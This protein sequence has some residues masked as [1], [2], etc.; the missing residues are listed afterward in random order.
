MNELITNAAK[1]I[2]SYCRTRTN[3]KEEA[4]DLSQDIFVE[5][6]KTKGNFDSEKAFYGFMWAV[7][8]NVYAAW[9]KKRNKTIN[10]ELDENIPDNSIPLVE[11][12]EKESDLRLLYREL[13]LL[14]EQYRQVVIQYYF[15]ERKVSD[16]SKSMNISE[17]MVKFLLFKTRKKLKEGMNM[18]RTKG[19]LSFNPRRM[20]LGIL[21]KSDY[22][23]WDLRDSLIAQNILLACYNDRCTAEEISIEIGV[24]VPY[25]E[26]ELSKLCEKGLLAQK[27]G[28]YETNIVIFTKEF[29]EEADEKTVQNRNNVA[30]IISK[31]LGEHLGDIKSVGF[32]TG[33][34]GDNMLKWQIATI[35]LMQGYKKYEKSLNIVPP[36]K[37]PGIEGFF[38]G[39]E[40]YD[41]SLYPRGYGGAE[42][43]NENG[44]C[45]N[46]HVFEVSGATDVFYLIENQTRTNIVLDIAKGKTADLSENDMSE[47]AEF[48]KRGFVRKT[49]DELSLKFPVYTS[50]QHK[51]LLSLTDDITT[52]IAEET[53]E[54]IKTATD[55]LI[56]H[57]PVSMKKEAESMAWVNMFDIIIASLK[58]MMDNGT[59]Q[60]IPENIY[61]T[62][63]IWQC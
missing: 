60:Q 55:I 40:C 6:L 19:D 52:A 54:F 21:G 58:I 11:M 49:G 37:Y 30:E 42:K 29:L 34:L 46:Y 43:S 53:R 2:F 16:I 32:H 28:K 51:E 9:Y 8:G 44:D 50:E 4:E 5:L 22:P 41:Q 7:A 23:F 31:F 15:N 39:M 26:K 56:Q 59:L 48:I 27:G 12:L 3:S 45:F 36:T 61:P 47:V 17:S 10:S 14:T 62:T 35:M 13:G 57:T 38:W 18:K 24:A 20:E 25:L 1:T 33:F 63:W